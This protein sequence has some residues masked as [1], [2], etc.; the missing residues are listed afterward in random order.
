MSW[1]LG[2]GMGRPEMWDPQHGIFGSSSEDYC[3]SRP[4]KCQT[5]AAKP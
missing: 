3:S 2:F 1:G 5:L 4:A